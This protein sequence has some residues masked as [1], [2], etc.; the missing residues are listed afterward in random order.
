MLVSGLPNIRYLSGF[1]GS[2]A[3]LLLAKGQAILF[4]DPRYTIQASQESDCTVR[5]VRGSLYDAVAKLVKRKKWKHIGIERNRLT[6]G[7]YS[8]IQEKLGLGATP[9][10]YGRPCREAADDQVRA[11]DAGD[12]GRR[13]RRTPRH[14]R[15][16]SQRF[17]RR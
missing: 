4:T 12:S 5:I 7:G 2:N 1:T 13:C 15:G 9:S 8:E 10:S 16:Q 14:S 3:L 11:G 6:F 17:A